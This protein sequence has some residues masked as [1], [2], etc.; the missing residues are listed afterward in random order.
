MSNYFISG[1]RALAAGKGHKA[2]SMFRKFIKE[3]PCKEGYLN[4]GNAYRLIEDEK[5]AIDS[6]LLAASSDV[7]FANGSYGE[8]D[9]ALNNLGLVSYTA[10]HIDEA[11]N[12]FKAALAINPLFGEA[13]WNI[14][15]AKLKG[16][17]CSVGW[18]EH[19]WRFNRG[20]SSVKIV[21][22]LPI[23]DGVSC[24]DS[25]TVQM[26]QGYGDKIM[27]GRYIHLLEKY[28]KKVYVMCHPSL[29]CFF[30]GYT[31]CRAL[32][33]SCTIPAVSLAKIFGIVDCL[34]FRKNIPDVRIDRPGFNIAVCWDGSPTHANNKYRSC[35]SGYMSNL[36]SFGTLHSITPSGM[37][38]RNINGIKSETWESTIALMRGMQLVVS[39]DTSIVHLA[40]TLGIPCIMIQ[41][42]RCSDFRWGMPG[43]TNV[44]YDSV[45]VVDNPGTWEEAFNNVREIMKVIK[46]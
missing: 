43:D 3:T 5:A 32:T 40:G 42:R 17:N 24:G 44:W 33:G 11:I 39:V 20:D 34:E 45:M 6:Y 46:C 30:S 9:L 16:S 37:G 38:G 10:N 36:S 1:H 41:P 22:G 18:E 21:K 14:S 13:I 7:A 27:F 31:C 19:E 8:F 29:D 15:C 25:I 26:E 4:L 23:W 2:I 35:P 28:F 12:F